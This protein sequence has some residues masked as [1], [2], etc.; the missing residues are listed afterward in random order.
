MQWVIAVLLLVCAPAASACDPDNGTKSLAGP[1]DGFSFTR[2]LTVS[3]SPAGG[4]S[5][6]KSPNGSEFTSGASVTL[7]AT[8]ASGYSFTGWQGDASGSTNPITV[9][10]DRN[11]TITA[12]FAP[13][14]PNQ[15][16]LTVF[17]SPAETGTIARDPDQQQ[18][19]A[20]TT[21]M[22]TATA[23]SGYEFTGW[24]GDADGSTNPIAVTMDKN[25]T[26]TARFARVAPTYYTVTVSASPSEA[27]EIA[28]SPNQV[29]YVAGTT[30]TLTATAHYSYQ[31]TGWQGD[32]SGS[33]NPTSITVNA[34]KTVTGT[35]SR[36]VSTQFFNDTY[37]A[38]SIIS[39]RIDGQERLLSREEILP[40]A[41]REI[42]VL[43]G[44]HSYETVHGYFDA[45]GRHDLYTRSGSYT[46]TPGIQIINVPGRT[47]EDLLTPYYWTGTC[48]AD[49]QGE[50]YA[51]TLWFYPGGKV[52]EYVGG[53]LRY[54]WEGRVTFVRQEPDDRSVL[55][56]MPWDEWVAAPT[57]FDV[58][59]NTLFAD[60]PDYGYSIFTPSVTL[61]LKRLVSIAPA[62]RIRAFRAGPA[63]HR[64]F[65][66]TRSASPKLADAHGRRP[67]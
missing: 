12:V 18:Y 2:T 24:Q 15:Y 62:A 1:S 13:I 36:I 10:M 50:K 33:T 43:P 16:T 47:L 56:K 42:S 8:S 25:K 4:G 20:G 17:A 49:E 63:L 57:H 48:Q 52:A 54:V 64:R 28:R 23:A 14:P 65:I 6:T 61:P 26:M 7:T 66:H 59:K 19:A 32:A 29:Q 60:C 31:F 67:L 58:P 39:L 3:A 55:L 30:V 9:K 45:S 37:D 11:R 27:G 22:V 38:M 41:A 40:M 5:I 34:N 53:Q 21:V 51:L 35:F 44:F 46:Q